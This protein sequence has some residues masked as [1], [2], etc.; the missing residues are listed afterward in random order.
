MTKPSHLLKDQPQENGLATPESIH[1]ILE[2]I[3]L[4]DGYDCYIC[5]NLI[6]QP[7]ECRYDEDICGAVFCKRCF[8]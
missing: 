6:Y 5:K 1:K 7:M 8:E 3:K 2:G 4:D